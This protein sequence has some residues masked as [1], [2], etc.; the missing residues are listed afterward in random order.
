MDIGLS[1][2]VPVTF[3]RTTQRTRQ[4]WDHDDCSHFTDGGTSKFRRLKHDRGLRL[5]RA[6]WPT[7][8]SRTCPVGG[9]YL[10]CYLVPVCSGSGLIPP[11]TPEK[12]VT[13]LPSH[14]TQD[15]VLLSVVIPAYNEVATIDRIIAA[16]RNVGV[17]KEII[18]VDDCST[19]GTRDRLREIAESDGGIRVVYHDFNQGKGAALR[20]GF[21]LARGR[22]VVVQDADLE[23]DPAEY[24]QAA[25]AARRGQGGRRIWLAIHRRRRPP[26][27]RISGTRSATNCSRCCRTC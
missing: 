2:D 3:R 14:D 11:T 27:A 8:V 4:A 20:T 16:V 24:P 17:Q 26:G 21:A 6:S 13:D 7:K 23:Y 12:R 25:R 9:L 15:A 22:F 1:S 5:L 19:D 18:V 10:Y